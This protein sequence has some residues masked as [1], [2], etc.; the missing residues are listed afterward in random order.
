[1]PLS[2]LTY[3]AYKAYYKARAPRD[4]GPRVRSR[5]DFNE[6]AL[7]L[8]A[9]HTQGGLLSRS[10]SGRRGHLSQRSSW[11]EPHACPPRRGSGCPPPAPDV[12][13]VSEGGECAGDSTREFKSKLRASNQTEYAS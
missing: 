8:S 3:K 13:R 5:A 11:R 2:A 7:T 4:S 10:R 9:R 12:W 6:R 1:P